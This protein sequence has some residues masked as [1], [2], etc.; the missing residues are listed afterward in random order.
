[1]FQQTFCWIRTNDCETK[2]NRRQVSLCLFSMEN[3]SFFFFFLFTDRTLELWVRQAENLDGSF[4][5]PWN[6]S[7]TPSVRELT[8]HRTWI[9]ENYDE[10]D[11]RVIAYFIAS[12]SIRGKS[13]TRRIRN[14]RIAYG[15]CDY[16]RI[17][18]L[19]K[20]LSARIGA[21]L[22]CKGKRTSNTLSYL[23]NNQGRTFRKFQIKP[24]TRTFG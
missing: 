1:M 20:N 24:M 2:R 10:S 17:K 3:R 18:S 8:W 5:D 7:G 6:V 9:A 12:Q 4:F 11:I 15:V 14:E 22:H 21:A 13:L 19:W 16:E 23:F